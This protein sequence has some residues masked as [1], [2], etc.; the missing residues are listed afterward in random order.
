MPLFAML[1]FAVVLSISG[2]VIHDL[3]S[4]SV[5]DSLA[6]TSQQPSY[7]IWHDL[8]KEAFLVLTQRSDNC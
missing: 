4:N 2:Y 6:S 3:K 5:L 1:L 7:E 8:K